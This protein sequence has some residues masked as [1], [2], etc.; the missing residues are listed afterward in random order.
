MHNRT[1]LRPAP[2]VDLFKR[3]PRHSPLMKYMLGLNIRRRKDLRSLSKPSN[4]E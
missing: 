3:K 4:E 1:T 2:A